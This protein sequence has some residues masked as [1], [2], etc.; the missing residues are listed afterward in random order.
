[1]IEKDDYKTSELSA[2]YKNNVDMIVYKVNEVENRYVIHTYY[3]YIWEVENY[4]LLIDSNGECGKLIAGKEFEE[5]EDMVKA[6]LEKSALK[7]V[8]LT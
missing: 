8:R 2:V 6:L 1:M 3:S 5:L 4:Y 7:N